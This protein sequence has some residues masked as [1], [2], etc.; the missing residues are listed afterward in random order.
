MFLEQIIVLDRFL[1]HHVTLKTGVMLQNKS[2][3]H[4]RNK[5]HFRK[6]EKPLFKIVIKASVC[7]REVTSCNS[8]P[9][10]SSSPVP[11]DAQAPSAGQVHSGKQQGTGAGPGKA[12][13]PRAAALGSGLGAE[14]G[15]A[16]AVAGPVVA[17]AACGAPLEVFETSQWSPPHLAPFRQKENILKLLKRSC[18]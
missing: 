6:I 7:I 18:H 13:G 16:A 1:K 12:V 17:P 10:S 15:A 8:P 9:L 11:G 4:H 14:F 5:S 3:F 2:A